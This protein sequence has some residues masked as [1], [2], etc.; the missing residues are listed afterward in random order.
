MDTK[1]LE[2]GKK[3]IL[4]YCEQRPE[5]VLGGR[6]FPRSDPY[7]CASLRVEIKLPPEYPFKP[8]AARFLDPIHHPMI[9][10]SG[11]LCSCWDFYSFTWVPTRKIVDYITGMINTIDNPAQ[12]KNHDDSVCYSEYNSNYSAFYEKAMQSVLTH[13]QSRF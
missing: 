9:K 11:K 5:I 4:D 13:G 10:T 12:W 6:I 8:P 2:C 1:R 7:Y 3:F